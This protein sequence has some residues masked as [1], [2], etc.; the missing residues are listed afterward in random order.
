MKH[1]DV[2]VV[3]AG[4]AGI[5]VSYR[6][7]QAGLSHVVLEKNRICET[8]RTQR[9]NSFHMNTPN[10][11]TVLPGDVYQGD[12]PEGYM[13]CDAFI[14]LVDDYARRHQLPIQTNTAV[15]EV[16]QSGREFRIDVPDGPICASNVVIA[17]GNLNVPKRPAMSAALPADINQM[18]GSDYRDARSLPPGAILVVGC[19]NSGG[20]IAEDIAQSGRHVFLS[21]GRNG[22]VPRTYRGRDIF[23]WLTATGRMA[24]PRKTQSGRGLIGATHTIS[25]QSLSAQ[26]IVLLGRLK[27]IAPDGSLSFDDSVAD[28]AAF[29]DTMADQLRD[30]IDAYIDEAGIN[31]P[32]AVPDPAETVPPQFADPPVRA[33]DLP[34]A[35]ITTIVWCTGFRGDFSW[36]RVPGAV[37]ADGRPV[38][39]GGVSAVSGIY[40]AG[41]DTGESLRA[42]TVL[43]AQEESG[44]IVE[45][46]LA[47]GA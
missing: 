37:D 33:L 17:T 18:D 4:W 21:T 35:G 11:L 43:A 30:E 47:R 29:A 42:G 22:R 20:Q 8:W 36:I 25:L 14:D 27:D 6:L 19:G 40:Y 28:S 10:I 23:V 9:W 2:V 24:K 26:G 31:A 38:Q 41:L 12:S 46:L 7:N 3:G 45:H 15:I 5:A 34:A 16:S 44:R 32:E 39:Q 1:Y 13:S